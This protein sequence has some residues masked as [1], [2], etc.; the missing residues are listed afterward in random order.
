MPSLSTYE[1]IYVIGDSHSLAFRFLSVDLPHYFSRPLITVPVFVPG[2]SAVT[3]LSGDDLSAELLA[4]LASTLAIIR[5]DGRLQRFDTFEPTLEQQASHRYLSGPPQDEYN[6]SLEPVMLFTAG[7]L[8][9]GEVIR[10][11]GPETDFVLEDPAYDDAVFDGPDVPTV[12]IALV[13]RLV[14]RRLAPYGVAFAKLAHMGF[15]RVYVRSLQPP[16]PDDVR[17]YRI[18]GVIS[19]LRLR[20]KVTIV[21]NRELRR[22]ALSAGARYL[23]MWSAF[24]RNGI[25]DATLSLDG[26]HLNRRSSE[27]TLDALLRD[28]LERR[29]AP[30][31]N[32]RRFDFS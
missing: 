9:A 8:D 4:A 27:L 32:E 19:S 18:R 21:V 2:L 14:E 22:L 23:D 26:D 15:D 16:V 25:L 24:S 29:G 7:V 20:T 1:P 13:E 30:I 3:I 6:V 31:P 5:R 12:P 28:V 17:A 10:E 11:L